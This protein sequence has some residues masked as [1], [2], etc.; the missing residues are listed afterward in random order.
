MV[1]FL[2]KKLDFL[3]FNAIEPYNATHWLTFPTVMT[4][5]IPGT[6]IRELHANNVYLLLQWPLMLQATSLYIGLIMA[7]LKLILW[8]IGPPFWWNQIEK[9]S[10]IYMETR[11]S[12]ANINLTSHSGSSVI[13]GLQASVQHP[14]C[15]IG[16]I[17]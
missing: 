2:D 8:G 11:S 14:F 17:N 10:I 4:N 15:F 5:T 13:K 6:P 12:T 7:L 3:G 1:L 16:W 9:H